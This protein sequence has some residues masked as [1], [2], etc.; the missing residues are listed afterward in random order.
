MHHQLKKKAVVSTQS[1]G[2]QDHQEMRPY[3]RSLVLDKRP[4]CSKEESRFALSARIGL[5]KSHGAKEI[6]TAREVAK[7]VLGD[8]GIS[9]LREGPPVVGEDEPDLNEMGI[10]WMKDPSP[11]SEEDEPDF[12]EMG[13]SWTKDVLPEVDPD[14][15]EMGISWMKDVPPVKEVEPDLNE[16][17]ISWMKDT[18]PVVEEVQPNLNEMGISWMK[19]APPVEEGSWITEDPSAVTD[20]EVSNVPF[21]FSRYDFNSDL[22]MSDHVTPTNTEPDFNE[23]G[24]NWMREPC[25]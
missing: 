19:D 20:S 24:I 18:P 2:D 25:T 16:M 4:S 21:G 13:I 6:T 11:A 10:D 22:A 5:K 3:S 1:T 17:G 23:M 12:N 7:P 15:N 9:W 8:M 14:L